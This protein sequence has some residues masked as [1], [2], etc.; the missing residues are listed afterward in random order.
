MK[1]LS[2][3]APV[4]NL[5]K[6]FGFLYRIIGLGICCMFFSS[7]AKDL[8][9]LS[10]SDGA[11]PMSIEDIKNTPNDELPRY[12]KLENVAMASSAYLATENEETGAIV[13]ASYPVYSFE[14][15]TNYDTLNPLSLMT[16]VIVKD[17]NF[18]EDSLSFIM[19]IEGVYDNENFDKTMNM[20]AS[21][22]INVSAD[23][24]LLVKEKSPSFSDS[25]LWSGLTG[26]GGLLI[27]LSFIPGSKLGGSEPVPTTAQETQKPVADEDEFV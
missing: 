16:Y 4:L 17:K 2:V 10:Q 15:L 5:L 25:L 26:L 14:Q 9:F 24:I 6:N 8:L 20:F 22:D 13:D 7:N 21:N 23:A 27:L 12:I 11:K 1:F 18:N 19:N 3:L